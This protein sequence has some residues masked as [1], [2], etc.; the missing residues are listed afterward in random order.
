MWC[1]HWQLSLFHIKMG[2]DFHK[3]EKKQT[4]NKHDIYS[5]C[6]KIMTSIS[7]FQEVFQCGFCKKNE[8]KFRSS[9]CYL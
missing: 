3:L 1:F 4:S 6:M 5:I 7:F 2:P 9:L 8:A